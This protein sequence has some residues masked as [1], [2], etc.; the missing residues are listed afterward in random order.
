M[1]AKARL[2]VSAVGISLL[3]GSVLCAHSTIS[4]I[5]FA[6]DMTGE[7]G[8]REVFGYLVATTVASGLSFLTILTFIVVG[9][10]IAVAPWVEFDTGDA[11]AVAKNQ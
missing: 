6:W 4:L 11:C 2:A 10:L 5:L 8:F 1:D 3:I 7:L 9:A